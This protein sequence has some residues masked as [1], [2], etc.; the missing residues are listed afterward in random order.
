MEVDWHKW[1]KMGGIVLAIPAAI[2]AILQLMTLLGS[3]KAKL[4][5]FVRTE[6]VLMPKP[7][8]KFIEYMNVI[9]RDQIRNWAGNLKDIPFDEKIGSY[10][11]LADKLATP[12]RGRG[13]PDP[14]RRS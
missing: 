13:D 12:R 9:D 14:V 6:E 10:K 5:A 11:S 7:Q 3:N 8:Q 1:A 4:V 2:L